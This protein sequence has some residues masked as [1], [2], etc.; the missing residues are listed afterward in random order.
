MRDAS[1]D[2]EIR[3]HGKDD[4]L[5][6]HHVF[7]QLNNGTTQPAKTVDILVVPAATQPHLRNQSESFGSIH[8]ISVCAF[9][10]LDYYPIAFQINFYDGLCSSCAYMKP[11]FFLA[12]LI[13]GGILRTVVANLRNHRSDLMDGVVIVNG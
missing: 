2:D 9:C 4:L 7:R 1:L 11:C 6:A 12:F 5:Y 13:Q 10:V 3:L 8:R